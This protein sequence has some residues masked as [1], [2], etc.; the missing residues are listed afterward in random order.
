MH[1][2][3]CQDYEANKTLQWLLSEVLGQLSPVFMGGFNYSHICWKKNPKLCTCHL[4]SWWNILGT[5]YSYR[6]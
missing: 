3:P 6:C 4:S 5:P 1:W 2:P